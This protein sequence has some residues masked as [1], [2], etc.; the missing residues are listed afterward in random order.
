MPK[1]DL[2]KPEAWA[3]TSAVKLL[4]AKMLEHPRADHQEAVRALLPDGLR[5][6]HAYSLHAISGEK[7]LLKRSE[8]EFSF[9]G[10]VAVALHTW[11]YHFLGGAGSQLVPPPEPGDAKGAVFSTGVRMQCKGASSKYFDR[12]EALRKRGDSAAA[13]ADL[14]ELRSGKVRDGLPRLL[15]P[16]AA[17][18]RPHDIEKK[19]AAAAGGDGMPLNDAAIQV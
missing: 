11:L 4:L 15:R 6:V 12:L 3:S 16:P 18:D 5:D 10:D 19:Q 8:F 14:R 17:R 2:E 13:D 7:K 9:T 1:K